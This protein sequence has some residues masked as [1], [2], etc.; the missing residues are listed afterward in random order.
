MTPE[1]VRRWT[2]AAGLVAA[3]LLL[4][5][6][7]LYFLY[8]GAPPDANILTRTLVS[9][10]A[11]TILVIFLAGLREVI[12]DADPAYEWIATL[13]FAGALVWLT[14]GLVAQSMEAG[15][16]IASD[17]PID[18]TIEGPLAPGQFLMWGSMGR[19]MSALFLGAAGLAI[20]RTHALP[21]WT[22]G[23]AWVVAAISL[24]FVPSIFF[25]RD[26]ASFYSAVG[27][28]TTA[29]ASG[30]VVSW[31]LLASIALLTTSG[32]HARATG[33]D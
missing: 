14:L 9:I 20:R 6:I 21:S 1:R 16:A 33:G 19:I 24:A 2:G 22:G 28:G 5:T 27:W 3:L 26:A 7:P 12:R 23:F 31:I 11:T 4:A 18:P 29:C 10:C 17:T 30:L 25:G 13:A 32:P 8:P 15:A